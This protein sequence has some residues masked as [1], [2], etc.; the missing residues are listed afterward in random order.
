MT[1]IRGVWKKLKTCPSHTLP[2]APIPIIYEILHDFVIIIFYS[3]FIPPKLWSS[4]F[5]LLLE[6]ACQKTSS[7]GHMCWGDCNDVVL[8]WHAKM[9]SSSHVGRL[10]REKTSWIQAVVTQFKQLFVVWV[11]LE[12]SK[13]MCQ[14]IGIISTMLH[15]HDYKILYF[16]EILWA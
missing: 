12:N 13:I 5:I 16:F 15:D 9:Q 11:M 10:G 8:V 3:I 7:S 2:N 14:R 4:V 6:A 1:S